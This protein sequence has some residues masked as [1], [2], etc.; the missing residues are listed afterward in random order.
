MPGFAAHALTEAG[1]FSRDISRCYKSFHSR[2]SGRTGAKDS[3]QN[4]LDSTDAAEQLLRHH[5]RYTDHDIEKQPKNALP[6][7]WCRVRCFHAVSTAAVGL[8]GGLTDGGA[9]PA[10]R[11]SMMI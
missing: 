5:L 11:W 6:R 10:V 3:A 2:P 7:V 4:R 8:F 1:S 9:R